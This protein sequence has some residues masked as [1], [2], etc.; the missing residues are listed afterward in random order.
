MRPHPGPIVVLGSG[1][2]GT[3]LAALL[4]QRGVETALLTRMAREAWAIEEAGENARFLP[5]VALPDSLHVTADAGR[6]L[7]R[8]ALIVLATPV[9]RLRANLRGRAALLPTAATLLS[10]G[11]GIELETGLRP[12]QIVGDV[13][14]ERG[15]ALL[16]ISGPN[17]SGE[18]ARGLPA[19][20][21][22]AGERRHGREAAAVQALLA[23]ERLRV[24]TSNDLIGVELGGALKNVIAVACGICDGLGYGHNARAGLITRGLAEM[25]RLAV[26]AGGRTATLAGLAGL[27]DLVATVSSAGS[28]NYTL[29]VALGCGESVGDVQGRLGHVAEGVATARAALVLATRLSVELPICTQL[30]A[31]LDGHCSPAAGAAALMARAPGGE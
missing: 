6:V 2:W 15:G 21:V 10:A 20:T 17:L 19:A 3:L 5:G 31:V 29:G 9:Q 1:A 12:S 27:G 30:V 25:T 26:A 24:Y 18:I 11:K 28:R 23:S 22:I 4:S 14:G 13:L 8:A 7:P 16:A